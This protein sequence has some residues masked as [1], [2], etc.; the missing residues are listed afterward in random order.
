MIAVLE[1]GLRDSR[2]GDSSDGQR[3]HNGKEAGE[4]AG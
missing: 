2:Y 4:A 3:S 1:N